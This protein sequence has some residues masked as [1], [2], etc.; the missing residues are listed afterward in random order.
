MSS[1]PL[2]FIKILIDSIHVVIPAATLAGKLNN[3]AAEIEHH[4]AIC[5]YLPASISLCV[6]CENPPHWKV[7][8][9]MYRKQQTS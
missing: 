5:L 8:G 6:S 3:T 2:I 7:I 9:L 4:T 1:T